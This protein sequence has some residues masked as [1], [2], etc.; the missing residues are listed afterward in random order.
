MIAAYVIAAILTIQGVGILLP[1][2]LKVYFEIQKEHP[3]RDKIQQW[4]RT[5]L[6]VV[7]SQGLMQVAIIVV[8]SRITTGM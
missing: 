1:I 5:Y 6:R 4:M 7:A 8:M 3:D 2:N